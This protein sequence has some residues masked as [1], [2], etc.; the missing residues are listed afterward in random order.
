MN[1]LLESFFVGIYCCIIYLGLSYTD[2]TNHTYLMLFIVGFMKHFFGYFL[3]IH[4][5][6][7]QY[8]CGSNKKRSAK[9]NV[10]ILAGES[11]L[12][13]IVFIILGCLLSFFIKSKI[14]LYF[15]LGSVL[16]IISE[17]IGLHAYF[18]N[19]RCISS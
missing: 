3:K 5:Y 7:C 1:Y 6:Y 15:I 14:L 10:I 9:R 19:E 4:D 8:G 12:E 17:K 13:G 18:C 11:I 2:M 16:H